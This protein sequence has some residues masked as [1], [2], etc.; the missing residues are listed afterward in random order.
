MKHLFLD[1]EDTI[2]T[3]VMSSWASTDIELINTQKVC[4]FIEKERPDYIH[5]YSFAI[6]HD[7]DRDEFTQFLLPYIKRRMGV[8]I[9][10]IPTVEEIANVLDGVFV[11][12]PLEHR[13]MSKLG[14]QL[15]FIEY[16]KK[17]FSKCECI[18]IDDMVEDS[19]HTFIDKRLSVRCIN[20]GSV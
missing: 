18:L 8:N 5:I 4:N 2:I 17:K 20:V 13:D 12:K 19:I 10:F 14:K 6:W 3:P 1:L 15:T 9:S 7:K 11:S 16:V